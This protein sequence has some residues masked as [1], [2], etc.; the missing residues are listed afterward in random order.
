[1]FI[2]RTVSI[3]RDHVEGERAKGA[4]AP[5][6]LHLRLAKWRAAARTRAEAC[7]AALPHGTNWEKID[8]LE[9][10][11]GGKSNPSMDIRA[12]MMD[13]QPGD[14]DEEEVKVE[15]EQTQEVEEEEEEKAEPASSART[16]AAGLFAFFARVPQKKADTAPEGSEGEDA[17]S[18]DLNM[19]PPRARHLW[20]EDTEGDNV[21]Q[22]DEVSG[23]E[24]PAL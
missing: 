1:M 2:T 14:D 7:I 8:W 23:D 4:P 10:R 16:R 24:N 13:L 21:S 9:T 12:Y 11:Y 22:D 6:K 3:V 18:E 19:T 17:G 20:F 5:D 15:N